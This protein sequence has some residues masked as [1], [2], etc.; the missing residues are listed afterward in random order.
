MIHAPPFRSPAAQM[1]YE[2]AP[3]RD[4]AVTPRRGGLILSQS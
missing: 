4:H 3:H 2:T 1:G